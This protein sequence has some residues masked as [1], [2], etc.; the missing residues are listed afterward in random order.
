MII[1]T[2]QERNYLPGG[3]GAI[4]P[5]SQTLVCIQRQNYKYEKSCNHL[6]NGI[7]DCLTKN[8]QLLFQYHLLCHGSF[9]N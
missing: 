9:V 2:G 3:F 4:N 6:I 7:I 1:N 5:E 8:L